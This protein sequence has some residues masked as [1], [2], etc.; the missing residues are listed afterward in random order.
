[1]MTSLTSEVSVNSPMPPTDMN[2]DRL[3]KEVVRL[4]SLT[5]GIAFG[6]LGGW[7]LFIATLWLVVKGGA[8]VGPHLGML[9]N[10]FPGY[11]VT[12]LGSFIGFAYGF[13]TGFLGGFLVSW[14]YN[15]IVWLRG[16]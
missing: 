9:V 10:Y 2:T 14:L 6:V 4:N 16:R 5:M 12:F 13:L 1:M 3:L 8:E 15:Q 7:V 11:R